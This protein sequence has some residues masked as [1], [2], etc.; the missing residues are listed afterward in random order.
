ML[1]R[2]LPDGIAFDAATGTLTVDPTAAGF[3]HL[4]AGE[5]SV[6]AVD[7][8]VSDGTATTTATA[9]ITVTGTND[10]PVVTGPATLT[11][12]EGSTATFTNE[13]LL[14]NASDVDA[15][16]TL[17]VVDIQSPLPSAVSQV[18]G[19]GHLVAVPDPTAYYG[20]RYD[21]VPGAKGIQIDADAPEFQSLAQG[22][23]ETVSF[24]Y[25]VSDG[26]ETVT[27]TAIFTVVGVN[28]APVVAGQV[29]AAATED[30]APVAIDLFANA[31]DVDHGTVLSIVAVPAGTVS[32][33]STETVSG[34][35]GTDESAAGGTSVTHYALDGLP[36][37]VSFDA[38]T[39]SLMVTPGAPAFQS[40][41][42]GQIEVLAI[43]YGVSDGIAVTGAT[44]LITITEIGR[45]H[46]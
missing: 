34:G 28:D 12:N 6:L 24:T 5:V 21:Y 36:D 29:G 45:A 35:N 38:A 26:I 7:Y 25:G 41:A 3:Q 19:V 46:V 2:S 37:G 10:A 9:L 14:A 11:V 33:T 30:S 16:D 22:E 15:H 32:A 44:A 1:F 18:D 4:A 42:A 27:T 43:D 8:G 13:A 39:G 31:S 20:I 23:T 40:L 17:Q